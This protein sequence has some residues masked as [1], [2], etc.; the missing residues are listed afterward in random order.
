MAAK[1]P[2]A[3]N[4]G[5]SAIAPELI[6]QREHVAQLC[7]AHGVVALDV[8]G[9]ASDGRFDASRS[10][11]DFIVRFAP[12]PS[13]SLAARYVAFSEALERALGRPVDLMTDHPIDNP[14]LR[15]RVEATR[16]PFYAESPGSTAEAPA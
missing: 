6:A 13:S 4:R 2:Q 8:F 14:Y 16:Q 1:N 3:D 9:S 7:R 10:D 12:D 5:M 15:A 11:F